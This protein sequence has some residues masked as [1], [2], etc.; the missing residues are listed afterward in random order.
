MFSLHTP[1]LFGAAFVLADELS[2]FYMLGL[3]FRR[4]RPRILEAARASE[5]DG[6]NGYGRSIDALRLGLKLGNTGLGSPGLVRRLSTGS[7]ADS[8]PSK[9]T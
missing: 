8:D 1:R 6:V 9:Y 3:G 2:D 5:I 4:V 7:F